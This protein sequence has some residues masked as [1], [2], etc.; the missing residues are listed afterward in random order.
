MKLISV[1]D[2]RSKS[3]AVWRELDRWGELVVTSN[4]KPIAIV[5]PASE[6]DLESALLSLRQAR[7][8]RS[9]AE[10]HEESARKG[11][12]KLTHEDIEREINEVRR[13]RRSRT[14]A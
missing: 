1:R 4:G 14:A 6:L 8:I 2:F 10:L 12:D 9:L 3:A 7:A 13:K 5:M 11:T